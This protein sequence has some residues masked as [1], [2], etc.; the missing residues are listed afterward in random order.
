VVV[1]QGRQAVLVCEERKSP[2]RPRMYSQRIDREL[3]AMSV[4]I[5]A[6]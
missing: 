6:A 1:G 4:S 2:Y 3:C 5:A